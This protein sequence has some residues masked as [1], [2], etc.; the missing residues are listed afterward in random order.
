MKR[1]FTVSLNI[2]IAI[3]LT[4]VSVESLESR[5]NFMIEQTNRHSEH[6]LAVQP[7]QV[8]CG[9]V[10]LR[11]YKLQPGKRDTLVELFDRVFIE[12][13]EAAGITVIGQ[14]RDLD[15]PD[16]F[17]WLRGFRDMPSRAQSLKE[18][19]SGSIWK[20]HRAEANATMVDTDNVLLLHPALPRSG[21]ANSSSDGPQSQPNKISP[22]FVV[23][24]IY[25]FN[26]PASPD[27]LD[28]FEHTVKPVI[29]DSGASVL[30]YFLTESS[31]NTYPALPVREGEH[32]FV[33]FMG[34]SD[35]ASYERH[36]DALARSLRW[37]NE[38]SV[39]LA[40]RLK[41]PP[42]VLRLSPTPRS[43]LRG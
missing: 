8:C 41:K 17:V 18:F 21:F 32:V 1:G 10:E 24:T 33:W 25:Y 12:S 28:F 19:Y 7:Q 36:A 40:R 37:R 38:I 35:Q 34:F 20:E 13:Q 31:A 14:F 43:H 39:E 2:A 5:T 16:R 9:I 15:D 29:A 11:Q 23:A 30:A 4:A 6:S 42:E 26:E 22:G 27:F 3:S